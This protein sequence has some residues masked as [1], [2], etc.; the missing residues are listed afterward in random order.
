MARGEQTPLWDSRVTIRRDRDRLGVP[1]ADLDWRVSPGDLANMTASLES[2]GRGLL[3]SRA[4]TAYLSD[5]PDAGWADRITGSWHHIGA[6]GHPALR[7]PGPIISHSSA[8]VAGS[9][10]P[11]SIQERQD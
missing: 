7:S 9:S 6:T 10:T 11:L 3:A 8:R 2:I 1:I 4:G 5:D